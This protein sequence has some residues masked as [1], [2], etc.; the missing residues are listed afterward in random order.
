MSR[1]NFDLCLSV[2]S[3]NYST[4]RYLNMPKLILLALLIQ[5]LGA[6]VSA[7]ATFHTT[8]TATEKAVKI[9]KEAKTAI[10]E[11]DVAGAIRKFNKCIDL[12]SLFIDAFIYLG[13][14]HKRA[15]NWSDA[16]RALEK[17]LQLNP[18]YEISVYAL[19]G[20]VEWEQNKFEEASQ[21][22][23]YFLESGEGSERDRTELKKIYQN[24][25]FAAKA[26]KNPVQF[27][28][29]RLGN[30]INT[31]AD[32]YF[33]VLT[34]DA[35][36]ILFTRRD[37]ED[38]NFYQS[39]FQS[40][41]GVAQPLTGVN[42][43]LNE[44]AQAISPDGSWIVFTACDRKNDGSQGGC[45]LYWSQLK[46]EGWTKPVPFS[47]TINSP[48]WESQPTISADGKTIIFSSNRPGSI[49]GRDLWETHRQTG[50]KWSSPTNLG[51]LINTTESE[52]FPF[53]HPDGQT[54]YFSSNGHPG[55]GREDL[56]LS[57]K[58]PNG[59]WGKPVN[60]GYPI[61][62]KQNE[63]NLVTSLNGR[64][65]YYS[66]PA[67]PNGTNID[68]F[69]FELPLD[70]R[71][72]PVTYVKAIVTD[73]LSNQPLVAKIEFTNLR[74]GETYMV[75]NTKKDGTFLVCL[76][77]GQNYALQI[78]KKGYLFHSEHFELTSSTNNNLEP[79]LLN[80]QLNSLPDSNSQAS[81]TV[82]LKNVFFDSG[83]SVLQ[84]ESNTELD[85]LANLLN[86]NPTL[87]LKIKGHTDNIGSPQKNLKLSNERALAVKNYLV[88]KGIEEQRLSAIG[89]GATN[90]IESNETPEGRA[91]NRR[92]EI[93][94][95]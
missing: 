72:K 29:T 69:Q 17:A 74:T 36:T 61:N 89:L 34:A 26:V 75:A 21:H 52:A 87:R 82:I 90:P 44:G 59:S 53:L 40:E 7:Q 39:Q 80:I 78:S 81:N 73:R 71:P 91:A 66:A 70:I 3:P 60:L 25:T 67:E 8:S 24:A 27:N 16:E 9:F 68:I 55:M 65:A 37:G 62:T 22:L 84:P 63:V 28:P 11:G 31:A 19:L 33:P 93:E 14:A 2:F 6:P 23:G 94:A 13:G 51:E 83:L 48:A 41:W 43:N 56:F 12:D 35:K 5:Y 4:A 86:E 38:E 95:F 47:N 42:T 77:I 85:A 18:S 1:Y 49:G 64:T 88:N 76:P 50:G 45:D 58:Q 20:S 54:L 32:E 57:R 92:T 46:Q 79:Y 10:Q 15:Q 30:G